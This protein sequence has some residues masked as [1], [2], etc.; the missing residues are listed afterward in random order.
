MIVYFE[1]FFI[2]FLLCVNV[3]IW[4]LGAFLDFSIQSINIMFMLI[5]L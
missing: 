5:A 4:T 3:D 1:I 2:R